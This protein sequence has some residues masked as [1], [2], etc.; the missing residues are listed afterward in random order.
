VRSRYG[1][2]LRD[3]NDVAQHRARR[4]ICAADDIAR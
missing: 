4:R 3:H 1:V 2:A